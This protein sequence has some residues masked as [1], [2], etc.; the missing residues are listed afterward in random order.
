MKQRFYIALILFTFG[1]FALTTYAQERPK[2]F[3]ADMEGGF[4][5]FVMAALIKKEVPL[6]IT[7]DEKLADYI[8]VGETVKGNNKWYDTVFGNEKARDQGS[9]QLIRVEDRA[10][11]WA[12][13]A[14]DKARF[15]SGWK[16]DGKEKVANRLAKKLKKHFDKKAKASLKSNGT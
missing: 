16:K 11:E 5:S 4:D 13:N 8:I 10:V 9:I 14:G 12:G 6:D 15:F 7:K 1:C 3:V 2:V